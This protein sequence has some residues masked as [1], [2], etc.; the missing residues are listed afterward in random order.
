MKPK[1]L[2][3][4]QDFA[5]ERTAR[6]K[7]AFVLAAVLLALAAILLQKRLLIP[8]IQ[9]LASTRE[10]SYFGLPGKVVLSYF[11]FVGLPASAALLSSAIAW[12]GYK[13]LKSKQVP[14]PG[15][16]AFRKVAIRRGAVAVAAGYAHLVPTLLLVCLAFWGL[17]QA[18]HF[19]HLLLAKDA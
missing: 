19:A 18:E 16:R 9:D 15:E 1:P 5:P 3:S 13:I 11:L 2:S 12:R 7:L 4:T 8:W 17:S 14:P 6:E 10:P